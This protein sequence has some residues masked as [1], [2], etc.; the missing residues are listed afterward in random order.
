MSTMIL[1]A[2]EVQERLP[3]LGQ[4]LRAKL[5]TF[6][7]RR[8]QALERR[9]LLGMDDRMLRDIGLSRIDALRA[10]ELMSLDHRRR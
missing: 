2:S 3:Q 9:A 4:W 8:Q 7:A 10:A 5:G 6:S 1:I